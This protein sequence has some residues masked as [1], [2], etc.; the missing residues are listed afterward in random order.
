MNN[1]SSI[2]IP[3][4]LIAQYPLMD[5]EKCRLLMLNKKTRNIE[6]KMFS[7]ILDIAKAGDLFVFNNSRVIKAR[8]EAFKPSGGKIELFL[9]RPLESS[10]SLN[11]NP[12]TWHCLIRGKNIKPGLRV[13]ISKDGLGANIVEVLSDGTFNVKFD[14]KVDIFALMNLFGKLPLPPYIKRLPNLDDETYYQ[15]VFANIDGSVAAPTAALHFTDDILSKM[16]SLGIQKEFLTLHVGYGTFSTVRDL[17]KHIMHSEFY[18]IPDTL[19]NSIRT[20][21]KR[22]GRVWAVGTTVVR[23]LESVFDE[24][25]NLL[26]TSGFTSLFIRP[27]Y[28][29]KVLDAMVTN[30]HHPDTTLIYLVSAFAGLENIVRAYS[31][32]VENNYRFLSYGDAMIILE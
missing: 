16:E 6:H 5:R 22:G 18:T 1:L 31:E 13:K 9:I 26:S 28:K 25:L 11:S 29:F 3:K 7:D 21:K 20:C 4:E 2:K 27:G 8:F 10:N 17:D 30:F 14:D 32:A 23:T 12:S 15:T 19:L 24:D